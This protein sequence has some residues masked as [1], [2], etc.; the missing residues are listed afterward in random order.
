M[1]VLVTRTL[2]NGSQAEIVEL[3]GGRARIC[4]VDIPNISYSD[5]W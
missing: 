5:V 4:L 3:I 1:A 2:P